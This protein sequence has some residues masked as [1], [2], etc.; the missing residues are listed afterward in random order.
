MQR[1]GRVER[2]LEK[3]SASTRRPRLRKTAGQPAW[4]RDIHIGSLLEAHRDSA[5]IRT[6]IS[7]GEP[8]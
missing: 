3:S 5:G 7:A 8:L 4:R 6:P 1:C 2:R